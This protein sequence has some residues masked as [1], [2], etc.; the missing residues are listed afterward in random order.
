MNRCGIIDNAGCP[1][2]EPAT[3]LPNKIINFRLVVIC[4]IAASVGLSMAIISISKLLL[5]LCALAILLFAPKGEN[6]VED[7]RTTIAVLAAL[8]AF[9]L[10][11]AWT[12]APQ[13][14]ALGSFAKYGKLLLPVLLLLLIRNRAEAIYALG[15]FVA[16]QLFL[17]F[18]SWML[19]LHVPVPWATSNMART[20]YAVFSSYLDQG[21]MSAV[22]ASLCWH[23]R[24]L[25]P[26]RFGKQIAVFVALVALCNVLFVLSGRSGH[27]VAIALLSLAIMWELP[28]KY[29]AIVV[30]LPFLIALGLFFSSTKV[31]ERLTL[32]VKEVQSYS[33][34]T[35]S[36]TSSGIRLGLWRSAIQIVSQNPVSGAGVGSWSTEYNRLQK[37]QNPSHVDIAGNGNPHQ[38]Y[39]QWGVQLGMPGIILLITMMCAVLWDSLRVDKAYARATQ[40][41]VAGLAV[42]CFFN[43][44]VYDALIGDFFCV[45]IG[46]LLAAGLSKAPQPALPPEARSIPV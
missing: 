27:V 23:L 9:A 34:E 21:I 13:A 4:A 15:A 42:A 40:S 3:I 37:M 10:S 44:T 7:K 28:K 11:L 1:S 24:L 43:S 22:F 35:V 17:L 38:E 5:F 16:A 20:E 18:S 41:V 2:S 30:F 8:A 45:C 32:V 29:R 46:L 26:G 33:A 31:R 25:A 6:P 36:T 19:F 12:V 39:L 14:E